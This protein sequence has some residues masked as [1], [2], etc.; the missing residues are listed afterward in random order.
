MFNK[1]YL[2]IGSTLAI[3][4]GIMFSGNVNAAFIECTDTGYDISS[5]VNPNEGCTILPPLDGHQNDSPKPGVVNDAVFFG[6]DDWL[7]DGKWDEPGPSGGDYID[8]SDL[9]SFTGAGQSGTFS[10]V[11]DWLYDDIMFIFKDG[12]DTNLTGYLIDMA[13]LLGNAY[14]NT[15]TYDTP[16]TNG[17]FDV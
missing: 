10:K 17:P 13:A 12:N 14:N 2:A 4:L 16:F 9:F 1:K 5:K 7:F 8:T 3:F 15:G 6:Y 11:G